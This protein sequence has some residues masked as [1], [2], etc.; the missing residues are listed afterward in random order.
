MAVTV[1]SAIDDL[2]GTGAVSAWLGLP[3]STVSTWRSRGFIPAKRWPD[4]VRMAAANGC[5]H[6]TFEAL[7]SLPPVATE[8]ACP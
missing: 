2:G 7:A 8:A 1:D 5:D 6:I 4:F 3:K